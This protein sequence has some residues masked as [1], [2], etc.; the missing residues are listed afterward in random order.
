MSHV[1]DLLGAIRVALAP[2]PLTLLMRSRVS[3]H[4][5]GRAVP[6]AVAS[7]LDMLRRGS[8]PCK[9]YARSTYKALDMGATASAASHVPAALVF[10]LSVLRNPNRS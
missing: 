4:G 9:I 1:T 5:T 3:G 10:E 6:N 7:G 8:V 2:A